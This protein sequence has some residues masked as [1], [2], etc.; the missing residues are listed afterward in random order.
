MSTAVGFQRRDRGREGGREG[1]EGGSV[2]ARERQGERMG[3]NSRQKGP[4]V[5]FHESPH[6]CASRYPSS[7]FILL[8][9]G[10]SMLCVLGVS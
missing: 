8:R 2:R 4:T 1:R 5:S 9:S 10:G 6:R 3:S 7:Y